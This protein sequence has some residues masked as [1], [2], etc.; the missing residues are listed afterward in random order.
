VDEAITQEWET[1][2]DTLAMAL[3]DG[4][5]LRITRRVIIGIFPA[6]F[7]EETAA[8]LGVPVKEG[9]R[10]GGLV[11]NYSAAAAGLQVDDVVTEINGLPVNDTTPIGTQVRSKRP[12]DV[13]D[14]TFYRGAEKHTIPVKLKG[15]P[16]PEKAADFVELSNRLEG[17]Y[18]QLDAELNEAFADY[19]AEEA[20]RQPAEQEWS[21]NQVL[22]HLIMS[23]R[24]LHN[25]LGSLMQ[26]PEVEGFSANTP[27]RIAAVLSLYPTTNELLAELRRGHAETVAIV[28][29]VPA[30]VGKRKNVLW[31]MNF[32]V[33]SMTTHARGHLD[34]IRAALKAARG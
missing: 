6:D 28:R 15:Y 19:S 8:K 20:A 16:I 7:N 23:E 11:P 22:A 27:A 12:G 30:E 24:W 32:E 17:V 33:D 29:N 18:S 3:E 31:W 34:Q 2:L 14:V 1:R 26:A 4:Q 25:W 10:V 13:V 5:D 9:T 21:A